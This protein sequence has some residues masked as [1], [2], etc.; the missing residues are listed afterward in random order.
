[1]NR[2]V[3]ISQKEFDTIE[4]YISRQMAA[5]ERAA[6]TKKLNTD[7]ALQHK[8]EMVKLFLVGIQEAALE[9]KL[10]E[11]HSASFPTKKNR[12]Q[13]LQRSY[14]LKKWLVAASV[15]V[16]IGLGLLFVF[17]SNT[18]EEKLFASYFQP[19]PGLIS[20]MGAS[21][22]YLFHSAMVDYKVGE[23]DTALKTWESLLASKPKNDTL[24][25]FVA[26]AYLMKEKEE[27]AILHFEKVI[28]I[29]NSPFKNDALWYIGLA[30]LKLNRETEALGFIEKAEHEN[31]AALLRE[32]KNME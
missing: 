2:D 30:L 6:F 4:Q 28:A 24:N 18:K 19:E 3:N 29:D 10:D 17:N 11:I 12:I 16:I 14:A 7:I 26:S 20:P 32:L 25:Y 22:N 31:K 1:M 27:M 21:D 9:D 23:Y 15:L 8:L 13:T 5:E